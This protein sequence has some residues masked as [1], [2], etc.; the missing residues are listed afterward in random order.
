[1][2][3]PRVRFTVRG[4]MI[5]VVAAGTLVGS[6]VEAIQLGK[7]RARCKSLAAYCSDMERYY[8]SVASRLRE[9]AHRGAP[10][11]EN[12]ALLFRRLKQEYEEAACYPWRAMPED[13]PPPPTGPEG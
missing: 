3:L 4:L 11:A 13:P 8:V 9:K 7:R 6:T 12:Q 1:M 5:A 2:R 10:F